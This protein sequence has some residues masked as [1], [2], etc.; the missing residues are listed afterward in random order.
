MG[1]PDTTRYRGKLAIDY[2]ILCFMGRAS[3]ACLA[4]ARTGEPARSLTPA[5][6]KS[7]ILL[8]CQGVVWIV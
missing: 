1:E 8:T 3:L 5:D 4:A 2:N 6:F 7:A